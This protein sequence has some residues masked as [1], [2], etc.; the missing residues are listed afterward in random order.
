M[1]ISIV[2]I[3]KYF[4]DVFDDFQAPDAMDK[5][6]IIDTIQKDCAELSLV[7]SAPDTLKYLIGV[8]SKSNINAWARL[9]DLAMTEYNPIENYNK[10]DVHTTQRGGQLNGEGKTQNYNYGYNE[11]TRN[12]YSESEQQYKNNYT[13]GEEQNIHAR[14]NI[15]VTTTQQMAEQEIAL[16]PK[17]NIYEYIAESFKQEFFVMMY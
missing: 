14:G 6:L 1:L 17:L 15:G 12:P 13:D 4:P 5:K 2:S 10:T 16:R 3:Y 11:N 9:W 8:W 7:Y